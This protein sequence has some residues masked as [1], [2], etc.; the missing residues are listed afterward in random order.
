MY[1]AV[2]HTLA[3]ACIALGVAA[4]FISHT[5]KRPAPMP[6]LYS[7][8]SWLGMSVLGLLGG[9]FC[10]GA[11]SYLWPKLSPAGR[12]ALGPLHRFLGKAVFVAGIATMAVSDASSSCS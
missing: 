3:L 12:R 7:A 9:Q 4:A 11:Y 5:A 10:L 1:H 2:L 8:H 6:N